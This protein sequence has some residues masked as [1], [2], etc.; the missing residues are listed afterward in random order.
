MFLSG[1]EQ[2]ARRV[3]MKFLNES[4]Q[5]CI[6]ESDFLELMTCWNDSDFHSVYRDLRKWGILLPVV[7][8]DL[9]RVHYDR[10]QK[11]LHS[12]PLVSE[13]LQEVFG[14]FLSD[15]QCSFQEIKRRLEDRGFCVENAVLHRQLQKLI[16]LNL[17]SDVDGRVYELYTPKE[18]VENGECLCSCGV[19]LRGRV[20]S[21]V[22]CSQ[23][24]HG[25]QIQGSSSG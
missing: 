12:R 21:I 14:C 4:D 20:G 13:R 6:T 16:D 9:Y 23:C 22:V 2:F 5:F 3:E 18:W 19:S 10:L 25:Y 24:A 11:V 1:L 17:L 8:R 7:D 15:E